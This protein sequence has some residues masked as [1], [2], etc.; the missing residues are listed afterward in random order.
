MIGGAVEVA[1]KFR[2]D[3]LRLDPA[4]EEGRELVRSPSGFLLFAA[5]ASSSESPYIK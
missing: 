2:A 5:A 1:A 4:E 3:E